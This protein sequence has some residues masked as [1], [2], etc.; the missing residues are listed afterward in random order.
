MN[1]PVTLVILDGWGEA[2][3]CRY[4]AIHRANTPHMDRFKA[5]GS[6]TTLAASGEE[7][8]LPPGQMGNSEVGHLNIGCGRIVRQ[9]LSRVTHAIHDGAF[10]ENPALLE[11]IHHGKQP[12]KA[13]HLLGLLS[14]GGVHS[15]IDHLKGLLELATRHGVE[16]IFVHAIL[17]GRDTPPQSALSFI[18]ELEHTLHEQRAGSIA[19]VSG[20][21]YTMDRDNRW[22]RTRYAYETLTGQ[23]ESVKTSAAQAIEASYARGTT[24][25]FIEPLLIH[26][27]KG[28]IHDG[29]AVI[30][31]NF[32]PD[33]A[34]QITRA[35]VDKEFASF[36]R[37][38]KEVLFTCMT[39]YD[40]KIENASVAFGPLVLK[41]TLG[42]VLAKAGLSQLRI[43][44]TEKYAHVTFFF[45][46][47]VETPSPK[48]T[49]ILIPSPSVSTYDKQP[50][51]SAE[52]LADAF[53]ERFENQPDDLTV[54]N[55][56]NAD[57][58]GHTGDLH[59]AIKA[60]ETADHALHRVVTAILAKG[61]RVLITSDHGNAETMVDTTTGTPMTAHTTSPV[62]FILLGSD[63]P[64]LRAEGRLCDIA[65]T[66]LSLL[67]L[68][69]PKEMT[70]QSL[71]A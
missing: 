49:R 40:A 51:M 39:E 5:E 9:S 56:A 57:M 52:A 6:F 44:E 34:R 1:R 21:Y 42:E 28:A 65:P 27:D 24:D 37:E 61:G 54:M 19:S 64:P 60:V 11:A 71:L 55:F 26:G 13:L 45:N 58:V 23:G 29:D 17:D 18:E 2:K 12:G 63:T 16:R 48:E 43:A 68:P 47:G 20:R 70:G 41:Q 33:R 3:P 67:G 32:R 59:S 25:E 7:V 10:F 69:Q 4:N 36:P 53:L 14:D 22:E 31:F 38:K 62:P 15:H 50:E 30:F 46:G 8:G 35:F 66:I